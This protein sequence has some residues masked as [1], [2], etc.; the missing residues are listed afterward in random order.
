MDS[1]EISSDSYDPSMLH[2]RPQQ[3][4]NPQPSPQP[5][6]PRPKQP[7]QPQRTTVGK[8]PLFQ[9]RDFSRWKI[10]GGIFL[11]IVALYLL[12]ASISYFANGA[13]DQSIV[14]GNSYSHIAAE[15][16]RIGN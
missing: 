11:I 3:P 7:S 9:G 8:E 13:D 16:D 14:E 15:S 12:I 10:F 5:K 1:F 6:Q 4:A 2:Q